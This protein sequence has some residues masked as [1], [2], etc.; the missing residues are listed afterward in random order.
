MSWPGFRVGHEPPALLVHGGP[1]VRELV[2]ERTGAASWLS[3][4]CRRSVRQRPPG[5]GSEVVPRSGRSVGPIFWC[6]RPAVWERLAS[7]AADRAGLSYAW[8]CQAGPARRCAWRLRIRSVAV[9]DWLTTELGFRKRAMCWLGFPG[10]GRHGR[11]R[12]PRPLR[13]QMLRVRRH[14]VRTQ[15]ATP[16]VTSHLRCA[17]S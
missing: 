16:T 3:A 8:S 1:S 9:L 12:S 10:L 11:D 13:T 4:Q 15:P 2:T 14:P 6:S 5:A 7:Q 17:S